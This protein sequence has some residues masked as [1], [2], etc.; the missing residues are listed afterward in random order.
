APGK[1]ILTGESAVLDGA[2]A[3][4]VAVDRRVVARRHADKV[5]PVRG[6]ARFLLAVADVLAARVGTSAAAA[7]LEV[8]CDSS[9]FYADGHKLGLGSSAAVT[10]AATALALGAHD[11][12]G[13]DAWRARVRVLAQEAHR[14]AQGGGSGAD[15]AAC[16][17]GGVIEF[18]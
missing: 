15:I 17:Y 4:V 5:G 8:A 16:V 9:A 11:D 10:V 7:A 2:P 3:L 12:L 14:R 13:D 1:L 6:S 18:R